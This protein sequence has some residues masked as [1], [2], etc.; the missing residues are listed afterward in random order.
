MRPSLK[1][2]RQARDAYERISNAAPRLASTS[3][4]VHDAQGRLTA[5]GCVWV[6]FQLA[7]ASE[8]MFDLPLY[9]GT[10]GPLDGEYEHDWIARVSRELSSWRSD[11][12]A[13]SSA[14]NVMGFCERSSNIIER[15]RARV[16]V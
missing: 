7:T 11:S 16:P 14:E 6:L 4:H 12:K 9:R 15:L 1:Q 2:R 3:E 10:L 5:M 13:S 8:V